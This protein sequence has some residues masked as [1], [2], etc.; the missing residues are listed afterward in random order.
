MWENRVYVNKRGGI[1]KVPRPS[2][3]A[4][5]PLT[6]VMDTELRVRTKAPEKV[7]QLT[8]KDITD[9]ADKIAERI[10]NTSRPLIDIKEEKP[11]Y[12]RKRIAPVEVDMTTSNI[13]IEGNLKPEETICQSD[14][15][16]EQPL[17]S[18]QEEIKKEI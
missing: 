10:N 14:S 5:Q 13:K 18:L 4:L 8:E 3:L 17:C 9:I 1:L 6:A 16:L 11:I 2:E 15:M 7:S 12:K